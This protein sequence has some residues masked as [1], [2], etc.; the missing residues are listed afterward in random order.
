MSKNYI[1]KHF[2]DIKKHANVVESR[3]DDSYCTLE[4]VLKDNDKVLKLCQ[5][6]NIDY[7][8]IDDEYQFDIE[9]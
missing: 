7:T 1:N 3:I 4:S 2:D 8:L 9:L 5:I 6:H